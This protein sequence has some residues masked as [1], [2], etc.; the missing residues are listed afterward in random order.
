MNKEILLGIIALLLVTVS[1]WS[2]LQ[3]FN[4]AQLNFLESWGVVSAVFFTFSAIQ[5][6]FKK[7]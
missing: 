6:L 4:I 1:V 2:L 3:V 5:Q 7:K